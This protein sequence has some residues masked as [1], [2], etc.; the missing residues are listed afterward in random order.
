MSLTMPVTTQTEH[1]SGV[2]AL[3]SDSNVHAG[4]MALGTLSPMLV[5]AVS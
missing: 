4:I 2:P 5:C 3:C 1:I